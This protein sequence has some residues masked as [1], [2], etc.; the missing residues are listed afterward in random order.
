LVWKHDGQT[1]AE[2]PIVTAGEEQ[3]VP[4]ALVGDLVAVS[5]RDTAN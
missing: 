3:S 1:R 4:Q 5:A 2:E